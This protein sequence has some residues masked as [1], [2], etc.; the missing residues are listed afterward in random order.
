MCVLVVRR[1]WKRKRKGDTH[2]RQKKE[3]ESSKTSRKRERLHRSEAV[4]EVKL[5]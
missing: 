4:P 2:K 1:K 3:T 5:L